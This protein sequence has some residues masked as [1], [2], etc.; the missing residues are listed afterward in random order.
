MMDAYRNGKGAEQP[1]PAPDDKKLE[2]T[3]LA[4][5]IT[6]PESYA[7]YLS[8]LPDELFWSNRSIFLKLKHAFLTKGEKGI[9]EVAL[10]DDKVFELS[11][12]ML[13]FDISELGF[14]KALQDLENLRTYLHT[15]RLLED[16]KKG[17]KTADEVIEELQAYKLYLKGTTTKITLKDMKDEVLL[18][19][20]EPVF[21][22]P[23]FNLPVYP[24]DIVLISAKTGVGKTTVALNIIMEL[25][26]REEESQSDGDFKPVR[27]ALFFTYEIP[28]PLLIK[29]FAANAFNKPKDDVDEEDINKFIDKYG[30]NLGIH[31][32]TKFEDVLSLVWL[33]HPDVFVI[34]YD[35]L[36]PTKGKFESEER[37][38]AFI[39]RS[40]KDVAIATK[41]VCILLSQ[42][43]EDGKARYSREKEHA[44]SLYIYL[45]KDENADIIKYS[46]KKNR[47]GR[48]NSGQL[49]VNWEKVQIKP[50]HEEV[51][52]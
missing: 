40:L 14:K 44:A 7:P 17:N 9:E 24:G 47:Y 49:Q 29:S 4:Y 15:Q 12:Y 25:F 8:K 11:Q 16:L 37:R 32:S 50:F 43:N 46:I 41:S 52:L 1:S 10:E 19:N 35:Q 30:N 13:P 34:D 18:T 42:V 20:L 3:L 31:E 45:E 22:L 28:T 23:F 27:K 2:K 48:T 51:E 36:V 38:L 5:M 6:F 39:V 21:T 33:F 26:K